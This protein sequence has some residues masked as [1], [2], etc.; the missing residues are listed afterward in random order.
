MVAAAARSGRAIGRPAV[1]AALVA[2]GHARD[3]QDAFTRFLAE[4]QPG[5]IPRSGVVPAEIVQWIGR[6]GG[7]ASIAHPGKYDRDDL[8]P[9]LAEAGMAAIE[10]FHPDHPP[11]LV[12]HYRDMAARL[13]LAMTGGSDYHGPGSGRTGALGRVGLTDDAFQ[14]LMSRAA[15][16]WTT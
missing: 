13:G 7:L 5:Y 9:G 14:A 6:V 1:A 2:A 3:L 16:S 4:G 12:D 15:G 11:A 10:V 8:I